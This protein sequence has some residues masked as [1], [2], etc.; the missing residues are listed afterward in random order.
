MKRNL[1]TYLVFYIGSGI[2]TAILIIYDL[3]IHV[4]KSSRTK[5]PS[6]V[7]LITET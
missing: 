3:G 2:D 4:K 6:T 5:K 7:S 1:E